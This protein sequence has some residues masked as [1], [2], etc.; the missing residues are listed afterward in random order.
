MDDYLDSFNVP[1][2]DIRVGGCVKETLRKGDGNIFGPS[3]RIC[4]NFVT[5]IVIETVL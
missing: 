2:E 3:S 5:V 4:E 1:E